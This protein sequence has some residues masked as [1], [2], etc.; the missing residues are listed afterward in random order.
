MRMVGS[1][2]GVQACLRRQCLI[3]LCRSGS[4]RFVM[5]PTRHSACGSRLC[6]GGEERDPPGGRCG[7]RE[8]RVSDSALGLFLHPGAVLVADIIL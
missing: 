7:R 6:S 2:S 1:D 5:A 3:T 4:H 8:L